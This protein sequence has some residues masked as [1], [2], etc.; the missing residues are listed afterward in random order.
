MPRIPPIP[1]RPRRCTVGTPLLFA[2][3]AQVAPG[4]R[5]FLRM[6]EDLTGVLPRE[7]EG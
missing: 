4:L 3:G 5:G 6:D 2:H 7:G 1:P